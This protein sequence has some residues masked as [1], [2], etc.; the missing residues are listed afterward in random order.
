ME[1]K[2]P[3][4]EQAAE[5]A[6]GIHAVHPGKKLAYN[7]SPS[8]NWKR[9]IPDPAEQASF[10]QR[11]GE[12]GY[13]WQFITLA[14]LHST[15]LGTATFARAFSRQ[16]MQA[17]VEQI[18]EPERDEGVDVLTHQKWSGAG[19]VD[20]LLA[21]VSGGMVSTRSMGEGVTEV[22]FAAQENKN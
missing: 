10:I 1:S 9:A 19:Y 18:Q 13:V 5:F 16:G 15:A 12:L 17:Y 22:Q 8:F 20:S 4:Y 2:I 14:G 6:E 11:L 3:S 21:M 7:L